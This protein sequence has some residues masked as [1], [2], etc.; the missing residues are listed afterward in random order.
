MRFA[1][2]ASIFRGPL[3]PAPVVGVFFLL[4]I[5]M[6]LGSLLY[7]PGVLVRFEGAS[8]DAQTI[9]VTRDG[10]IFDGKTNS[11]ADLAQL[12]IGDLKNAPGDQPFRLQVGPGAD[13]KLVEK[14]REL[15]QVQLPDGENLTSTD[16]PTVV[17]AVNF[18][19]Q[20]FFENQPVLA[21]QL[22]EELRSRF[23]EASRES[24]KLTLVLWADKAVENEVVM[25]VYRLASEVGITDFLLAERPRLFGASAKRPAP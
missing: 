21:G 11:A 3:D 18:R 1:R 25:R 15:F 20:F 9:T 10:V 12:R 6:L 2:Q 4:V 23:L 22:K 5:F 13:P 7:T 8:P 19:G 17:V 14:V 24:K 16:N